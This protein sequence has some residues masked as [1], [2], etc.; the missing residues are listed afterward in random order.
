MLIFWKIVANSSSSSSNLDCKTLFYYFEIMKCDTSATAGTWSCTGTQFGPKT[1]VC[2]AAFEQS[3]HSNQTE[4]RPIPFRFLWNAKNVCMLSIFRWLN[5]DQLERYFSVEILMCALSI[6]SSV[7]SH[8]SI[9][10]SLFMYLELFINPTECR[11]ANHSESA[12]I[13][14]AQFRP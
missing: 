7:D 6:F 1:S 3:Q 9:L 10:N 13:K 4:I 11:N 14:G 5:N 12:I 8:F 2:L